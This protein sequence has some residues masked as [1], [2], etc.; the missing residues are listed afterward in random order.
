[1]VEIQ[2]MGKPGGLHDIYGSVIALYC[3]AQAQ[4]PVFLRCEDREESLLCIRAACQLYW[5][6]LLQ[7]LIYFFS[8]VEAPSTQPWHESNR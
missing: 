2:A 1:M 5:N 4:K 7:A 3:G 6:S 8:P